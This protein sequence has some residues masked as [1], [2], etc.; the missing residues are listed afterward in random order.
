MRNEW[1]QPIPKRSRLA[2]H[3]YDNLSNE[4]IALADYTLTLGDL[5]E[6]EDLTN[7]TEQEIEPVRACFKR[8]GWGYLG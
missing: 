2:N 8:G 1:T 5:A 3:F 7:K 6:I 4:P